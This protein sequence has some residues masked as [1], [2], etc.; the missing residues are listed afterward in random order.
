VQCTIDQVLIHFL[1]QQLIVSTTVNIDS[2]KLKQLS[3]MYEAGIS[4]QD[5]SVQISMDQKTVKTLLKL[6]GYKSLK[7]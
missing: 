1:L 4:I 3:Q 5:I 6:L 2:G 7:F